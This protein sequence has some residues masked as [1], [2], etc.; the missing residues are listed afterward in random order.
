VGD[1]TGCDG[2]DSGDIDGDGDTDLVVTSIENGVRVWLNQDGAGILVEVGPYFCPGTFRPQLLDADGDGDLDMITANME[3]GNR[4][5][6][7][8]G[9]A[10]F[11]STDQL[12]GKA[13]AF[14][15]AVG[16]LDSDEDL[17]VVI[18][19]EFDGLGACTIYFGE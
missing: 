11:T 14:C 16:R 9:S 13:W 4:L 2:M 10:T 19:S 7:N 15:F 12:L 18:G 8:S 6:I 17:D 1:E 3:E 5:W